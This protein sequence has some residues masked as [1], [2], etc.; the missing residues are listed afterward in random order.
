MRLANV[1]LHIYIENIKNRKYKKSKISDIF[2]RKNPIYINDI[3][4]G[5]IY[6]ANPA[7]APDYWLP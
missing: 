4:I 3:Y 5:D 6:Q 2:E 7:H 1:H